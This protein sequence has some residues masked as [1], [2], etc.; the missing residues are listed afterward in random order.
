MGGSLDRPDREDVVSSPIDADLGQDL[1]PLCVVAQPLRIR[2]G[3]SPTGLQRSVGRR[4]SEEVAGVD[5]DADQISRRPQLDDAPVVAR[6]PP[7]PRL[8]AV[9][10][11][12]AVR[13]PFRIPDGLVGKAQILRPREERVRGQQRASTE[14][15]A[16][17]VGMPAKTVV[18]RIAS[19]LMGLSGMGLA[20]ILPHT[21]H[22]CQPRTLRHEC[23]HEP[24]DILGRHHDVHSSTGATRTECPRRVR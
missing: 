6:R 10:P 12:S 17:E 3:R 22:R 20:V 24:L 2:V 18:P 16:G 13:V 5:V 11:L 14:V 19:P 1:D 23:S 7:T 9:H 21:V 4:I 15:G 8:P